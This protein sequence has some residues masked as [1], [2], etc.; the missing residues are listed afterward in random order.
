VIYHY[1]PFEAFFDLRWPVIPTQAAGR[2]TDEESEQKEFF[3]FGVS[4]EMDDD[5]GEDHERKRRHLKYLNLKGAGFILVT[6]LNQIKK[7]S[8]IPVKV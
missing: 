4:A 5:Q 7:I 6:L 2:G 1:C 8:T 3:P